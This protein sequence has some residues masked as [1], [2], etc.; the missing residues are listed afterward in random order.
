MYLK[1]YLLGVF[2]TMRFVRMLNSTYIL[3]SPNTSAGG[4]LQIIAS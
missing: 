2:W 3:S 1:F 4:R